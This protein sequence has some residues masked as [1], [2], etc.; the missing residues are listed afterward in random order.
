MITKSGQLQANDISEIGPADGLVAWYP[1]QGDTKDYVGG[2]D[3]NNNGAI[4]TIRG[5]EF[6]GSSGGIIAPSDIN[7][8]DPAPNN[9]W[10]VS[11]W[12]KMSNQGQYFSF[13]INQGTGGGVDRMFSIG[14]QDTNVDRI[15]IVLRGSTTNPTWTDFWNVWSLYTLTWN[16]NVANF[17]MN[18]SHYLSPSVGNNEP[19]NLD[20][21][22]IGTRATGGSLADGYISDV[23]IYNRAL[24]AE[25]VAILYEMTNPELN[26]SIKQTENCLYVKGQIQET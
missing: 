18:G 20:T 25:E 26:T 2:N 12:G 10:T 3:G 17:F 8:L 21:I 5:Y 9:L 19:D 16:G 13:F 22:G 6:D 23:R 7:L 4:P 24:S 1:L 15:R 11:F 14:Q